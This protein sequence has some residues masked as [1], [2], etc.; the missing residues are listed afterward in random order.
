M[1]NRL[2]VLSVEE[3]ARTLEAA[4]GP[5]L[6]YRAGF[7]VAYGGGLRASEFTHLKAGEIVPEA[8]LRRGSDRMLILAGRGKGRKD[9][10]VMLA[11]GLLDL[12][13]GYY[14][15][16][17]PAGWLLPGR[18]RVDPIP[19]RKFNR[20]FGAACDFAGIKKK[21]SPRTSCRRRACDLP[22][23]GTRWIAFRPGFL[24]PEKVL[25]RLFR[26]LFLERLAR[27][28]KAG[29]STF[30]GN[31]SEQAGPD[32]FGGHPRPLRK[33][34]WA[35]SVKPPFGGPEAVPACLSRCTRRAAISQRPNP[36]L[37]QAQGAGEKG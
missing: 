25:P 33:A 18:D 1:D 13:R 35:V 22:A 19:T 8:R 10:H 6:R 29:K 16:A 14:C 23:D 15:K 21:V 36:A 20:A 17:R 27:L 34:R 30:F 12:L 2:A 24:L 11:P 26:R 32:T 37:K 28:H 4:S 7:S 31:L 9:S 5:G 3:A